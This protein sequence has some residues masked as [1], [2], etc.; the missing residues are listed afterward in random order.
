MDVDPAYRT[1]W[2]ASPGQLWAIAGVIWFAGA[3]LEMLVEGTL[4]ASGGVVIAL[5]TPLFASAFGKQNTYELD[6]K[7][8]EIFLRREQRFGESVISN[9]ADAQR[10]Q[11]LDQISSAKSEADRFS[12]DL[13]QHRQ[14]TWSLIRAQGMIVGISSLLWATGHWLANAVFHCGAVEC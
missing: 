3:A 1:P 10:D 4:P 13:S 11:V 14:F 9:I 7:L 8:S 12:A 5:T 2:R 6:L